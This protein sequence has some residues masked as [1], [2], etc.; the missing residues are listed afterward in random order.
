MRIAFLF[1]DAKEV[2]FNGESLGKTERLVSTGWH[3]VKVPAKLLRSGANEVILRG[4]GQVLIPWPNRIEDGSYEFDGRRHQLALD[5]PA[6]QDAIHG[7]VRWVAWN[8]AERDSNRVV[9]EHLLRPQPGYPFPL[10]VRIETEEA[11]SS[12]QLNRI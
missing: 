4:R 11:F 10:E 1:N 5:D 8:V 12:S 9:M 2:L 3:R 7:L 6:E